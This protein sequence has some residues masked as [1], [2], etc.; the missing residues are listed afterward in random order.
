[1]Y[2]NI[3]SNQFDFIQTSKLNFEFVNSH[4]RV[5]DHCLKNKNPKYLLFRHYITHEHK[6][7][8]A[9]S[10]LLIFDIECNWNKSYIFFEVWTAT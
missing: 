5:G 7:Q 10:E 3:S 2:S 9:A 8:K 1:M 4:R 6:I